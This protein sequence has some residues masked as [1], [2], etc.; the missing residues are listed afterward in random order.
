MSIFSGSVLLF[1]VSFLRLFTADRATKPLT[2]YYES[3]LTT[4]WLVL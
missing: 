3:M 1:A 2:N 4:C